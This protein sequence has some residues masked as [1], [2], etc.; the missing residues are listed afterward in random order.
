MEKVGLLYM[1]ISVNVV[2]QGIDMSCSHSRRAANYGNLN[3][4]ANANS[5]FSS[6]HCALVTVY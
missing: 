6:Y 5:N 4:N 2:N 3:A 1:H